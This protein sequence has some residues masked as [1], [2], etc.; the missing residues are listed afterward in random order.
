M[1]GQTLPARPKQKVSETIAL[2]FLGLVGLSFATAWGYGKWDGL[3]R[4]NWM[5]WKVGKCI[6]GD[7]TLYR[8]GHSAPCSPGNLKVTAVLKG[9]L[10]SCPS[11][12]ERLELR[13]FIG[14]APDRT[15]A[16]CVRAA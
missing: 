8:A 12:D 15:D 16:Y 14:P 9:N 6:S 1:F 4:D 10:G 3:G 11:G 5:E 2:A 13:I 7:Q